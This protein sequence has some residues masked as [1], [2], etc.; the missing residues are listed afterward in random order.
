MVSLY[1][2]DT[3][4]PQFLN[5]VDSCT[6]SEYS[7]YQIQTQVGILATRAI[8]DFK[9]PRVE[10]TYTYDNEANA[11]TAIEKGYYFDND[12]TQ[13]EVNV[14]VSRMKHYWVEYQISQERNFQN[15]YYDSSI[16]VHSSGNILHNL[17]KLLKTFKSLADKVEYNYYR[18]NSDNTPKWGS[19]NE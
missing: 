10:L 16:R 19:I 18:V 8:A 7:N 5:S 4:F 3:L 14:I 1:W 2:E 11:E 13:K 6:L 9:F 15:N 12:I 17:D